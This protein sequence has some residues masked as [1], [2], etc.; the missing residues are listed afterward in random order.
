MLEEG[1]PKL[2]PLAETEKAEERDFLKKNTDKKAFPTDDIRQVELEKLMNDGNDR[3]YAEVREVMRHL[4]LCHTITVNPKNKEYIWESPDELELVEQVGQWH[5][6]FVNLDKQNGEVSLLERNAGMNKTLK[7][8]LLQ[9]L[10]FD[11]DRKMMSVIVKDLETKKIEVLTKGADTFVEAKL[12]P[13]F[14]EE[15][16]DKLALDA[17][18]AHI[19]RF[20]LTGLRTLMLA[21]KEISKEE[22]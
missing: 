7:Y 10:E 21:K 14:R 18:K 20:S 6:K 17:V 19:T 13:R 5:M 9:V 4:S 8:K 2:I 3:R 22:Y 15:V 12:H 1:E 11:A 16:D